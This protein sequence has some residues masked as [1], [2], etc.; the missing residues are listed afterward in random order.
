MD[1]E[2]MILPGREDADLER[3]RGIAIVASQSGL[4]GIKL[5]AEPYIWLDVQLPSTATTNI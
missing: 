4:M 1:Q 5:T 3:A 2:A